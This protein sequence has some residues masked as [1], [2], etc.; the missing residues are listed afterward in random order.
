MRTA[1]YDCRGVPDLTK[2]ADLYIIGP[3]FTKRPE[4]ANPN[5]RV[6]VSVSTTLLYGPDQRIAEND[7]NLA[8]NAI[9][10]KYGAVI[11]QVLGVEPNG[12]S[13]RPIDITKRG[14]AQALLALWI[15]RF[16]WSRGIH[17]DIFTPLAE[18]AATWD[19]VLTG[20]ASAIRSSGMLVVG[21]QY[22]PTGAT[23][24][25][26][27]CWWE[28]SPTSFGYTMERHAADLALF[29]KGMELFHDPREILFVAEL[30]DPSIYPSWYIDQV[31]AWASANGLYLSQGVDAA[32]RGLA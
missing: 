12:Y 8:V 25:C 15:S 14:V 23:A 30:R 7:Y 2:Y 29:R 6:L 3:W 26:N 11:D 4:V 1:L 31:K 22:H 17:F 16:S 20:M 27:G 18:P 19:G 28:Q 32:A 13:T 9:A 10:N 24:A 21:Q 5:G